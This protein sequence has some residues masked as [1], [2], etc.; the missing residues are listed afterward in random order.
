MVD[1]VNGTS[2]DVDRTQRNTERAVQESM[3]GMPF[4][5][6]GLM[7]ENITVSVGSQKRVPHRLGSVP[8][9]FVLVNVRT[10]GQ[11]YVP[12][13]TDKGRGFVVFEVDGT[14]DIT[15]DAWIW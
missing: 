10:M 6:D 3:P 15:F 7:L 2:P 13:M 11:T 4:G 14:G 12:A 8:R 9:G 5:K 1:R